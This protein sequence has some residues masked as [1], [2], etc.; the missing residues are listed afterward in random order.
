MPGVKGRSGGQNRK[1]LHL[2]V[3][4]GTLQA[5]RHGPRESIQRQLQDAEP[6]TPPAPGPP[7]PPQAPDPPKTLNKH[8]R[9][10]WTRIS[11]A[12]VRRALWD[13]AL[14][15]ALLEAHCLAYQQL[16]ETGEPKWFEVFLKTSRELPISFLNRDRAMTSKALQERTSD[17]LDDFR[18]ADARRA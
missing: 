4:E 15:P 9:L 16:I 10:Y 12:L 14:Y 13:P 5:S 11:E 8:G 1:P 18:N 7:A 17:T 3:L 2:H 6:K